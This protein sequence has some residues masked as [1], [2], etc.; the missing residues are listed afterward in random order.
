[1]S[2]IYTIPKRLEETILTYVKKTYLPERRVNPKTADEFTNH[3]VK[4]FA[5]GVAEMSAYFTSE[6]AHLPKNYL[7]KKELRAGYL[8]YFVPSNFLKV[9]YCLEQAHACERFKGLAQVNILDIGSGPGTASLASAHFW[10]EHAP[11]Q[12]VEIVAFDQNTGALHDAKHIFNN[13]VGAALSGRPIREGTQA[14]PYTFKTVYSL[15]N[16]K[17]ISR[18]IRGRF[19]IIIAANLI[20]EFRDNDERALF[21]ES[22]MENLLEDDGILIVIEPALRWTTRNLMKARDDLLSATPLSL[23]LPHKGGGKTEGVNILAPCLHNAPCPML[24]E[25]DRDWCH[26]YLDWKCPEVITKIDALI[27]N[28]KDYLKFSYL[29]IAPARQSGSGGNEVKQ[30]PKL[31]CVQGIATSS[32]ILR[33]AQNERLLAMTNL[34]R[35]VSAPMYSKGKVE[36]VLCGK[37]RLLH[38]TRQDKNSSPANADFDRTKRGDMVRYTGSGDIEKDTRFEL[39][40]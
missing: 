24:K 33:Q 28:R 8:L 36:L 18:S 5:R 15:L 29:V 39:V 20:G 14:P 16:H 10:R 27:G 38:V 22:V 31:N 17:N 40:S 35:V 13:Y 4:F 21:L 12:A 3:D 32:S 34:Y 2:K 37:E 9:I 19:N 26:M 1:M 6:R 30:S 25:S 11:D 7:N 23:T